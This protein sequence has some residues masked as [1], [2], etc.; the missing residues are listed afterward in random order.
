MKYATDFETVTSNSTATKSMT[1]CDASDGAFNVTLPAPTSSGRIFMIKKSDSS[2]NIV[3]ISPDEGTID[4]MTSYDLSVQYQGLRVQD[5]G[6][7][8][9]VIG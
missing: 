6:G 7:H 4:G 9:Y 5:C 1:L 2:S 3:T 8:Y